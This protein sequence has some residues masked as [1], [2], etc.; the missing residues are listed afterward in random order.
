MDQTKSKPK[1]CTKCRELKEL[2]EYHK[3]SNSKDGHA[4]RCKTCES[5]AGKIKRRQKRE[6]KLIQLQK[7]IDEWYEPDF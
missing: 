7:D 5:E 2:T 1:I 3:N 4:T 6:E